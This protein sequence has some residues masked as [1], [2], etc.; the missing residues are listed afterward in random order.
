MHRADRGGQHGQAEVGR[1]VELTAA[2]DLEP[3]QLDE[4]RRAP[5]VGRSTPNRRRSSCGTYCAA[6]VEVFADV[7]EEVGE[8]ERVAQV[9]GVRQW[10]RRGRAARGS[11]ASS[12]RSP[13]PSRPCTRAGRPTSRSVVDGE[14]HRHRAEEPAEAVGV[15]VERAHRVDHRL[16]HRVVGLRPRSRSAKN[17]SPKSA[18]AVA[19]RVDRRRTE[20]VDDVVGVAAEPIQRM[21]VVA[22]DRRQHAACSS[23]TWC[24]SACSA[25]APS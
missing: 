2:L 3:H 14:V 13:P 15:D 7:A 10:R 18:S 24:R 1:A 12:R 21:H 25:A 4:R 17:R 5:A 16:Q 23:S 22:L 19:R 8:L 6:A 9:A 20:V 11:A